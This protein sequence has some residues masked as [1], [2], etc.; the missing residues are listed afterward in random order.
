[1]AD[2]LISE[3]G[4]ACEVDAYPTDADM[5]QIRDYLM[6]IKMK[7]NSTLFNFLLGKDGAKK[8]KARIYYNKNRITILARMAENQAEISRKKRQHRLENIEEERR[9]GRERMAV[10]KALVVDARENGDPDG[11]YAHYKEMNARTLRNWRKNNPLQVRVQV[12][13]RAARNRNAHG[14]HTDEDIQR[15]KNQQR[16]KCAYCRKPLGKKW[17]IDHIK[18]ISKGGSNE[19]SNIQLTCAICNTKK[20]AH[21]P[22]Y[23][24]QK[25][26]KLL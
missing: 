19:P 2:T 18:P 15:I 16:N 21:D 1:M 5:L 17:H 3:N 20:N 12:S 11:I 14:S 7:T 23:F 22:I 6:T 8:E 13:N 9:K 4:D 25:L 26:G 10:F 24:A